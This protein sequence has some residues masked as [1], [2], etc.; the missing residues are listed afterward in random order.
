MQE[1]FTARAAFETGDFVIKKSLGGV[2]QNDAKT[3]FPSGGLG[4]RDPVTS[5][6][7]EKKMLPRS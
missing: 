3:D 1:I 4:L 5:R 2:P 7:E 6:I